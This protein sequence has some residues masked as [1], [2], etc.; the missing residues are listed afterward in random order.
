MQCESTRR[1][2]MQHNSML[3]GI[4]QYHSIQRDWPQHDNI[5]LELQ[6]AWKKATWQRSTPQDTQSEH[7]KQK[8]RAWMQRWWQNSK[9]PIIIMLCSNNKH[10]IGWTSDNVKEESVKQPKESG[11]PTRVC[12]DG[13]VRY[14]DKST[15]IRYFVGW[16]GYIPAAD[17]DK[18]LKNIPSHFIIWY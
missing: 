10:W 17:T 6:A 15:Q 7:P 5:W 13:N 11:S 1:N 4:T 16:Y 8:H 9:P 3:Q 18:L 12:V 2:S 14:N